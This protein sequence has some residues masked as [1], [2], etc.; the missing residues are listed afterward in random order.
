MCRSI[1]GNKLLTTENQS[2]KDARQE[3]FQYFPM[4]ASTVSFYQLYPH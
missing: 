1:L 4:F 2:G 3:I